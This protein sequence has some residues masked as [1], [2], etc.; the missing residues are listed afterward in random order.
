MSGSRRL[1]SA[2]CADR[3]PSCA[4]ICGSA[5]PWAWLPSRGF[6][7]FFYV[8]LQYTTAVQGLL[9]TAILPIFVLLGARVFLN[10]PITLR[11]LSGV[12]VSILGVVVIVGR[13]Q[14]QVLLDLV[15]NIGDV[16]M[17][18]AVAP[19][20]SADHPDPVSAQGGRSGGIS[21]R[22]PS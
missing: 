8:A 22:P 19:L 5:S 16:W 11:Q 13:G 7:C 3:C 18:G 14:P 6:N 12:I 21:D 1:R 17:L 20:G 4:T 2:G 15:V 10:Q 9:I